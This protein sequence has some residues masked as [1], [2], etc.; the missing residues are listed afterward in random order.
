LIYHPRLLSILSQSAGQHIYCREDQFNSDK[1]IHDTFIYS[2]VVSI[3][4]TPEIQTIYHSQYGPQLAKRKHHLIY[5]SSICEVSLLLRS[6]S[7]C[8]L[9]ERP[10]HPCRACFFFRIH[11]SCIIWLF[12]LSFGFPKVAGLSSVI[13]SV[14]F[15]FWYVWVF[16]VIEFRAFRLL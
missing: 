9:T 7:F 12:G 2:S 11:T 10:I 3:F 15:Q 14:G 4:Q 6:V 1:R 5:V 8:I 13:F 16:I